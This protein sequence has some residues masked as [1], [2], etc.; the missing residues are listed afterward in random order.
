MLVGG[1]NMVEGKT[2][3]AYSPHNQSMVRD[4]VKGKVEQ[5]SI[6]TLQPIDHYVSRRNHFRGRWEGQIRKHTHLT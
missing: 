5:E 6:L 2:E 4:V 1:I 3:K